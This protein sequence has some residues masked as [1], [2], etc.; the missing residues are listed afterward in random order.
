MHRRIGR[1][2]RGCG[3]FAAA[4][5]VATLFACEPKVYPEA[6]PERMV[7]LEAE[8]EPP[9]MVVLVTDAGD[10]AGSPDAGFAAQ[11]ASPPSTA[12]LAPAPDSTPSPAPISAADAGCMRVELFRDRDGDG[13][14]SAAPDDLIQDC[15]PV[16]GY[17]TNNLDCH[18]A[19]HTAQDP[20][21]DV[22][23]GQTEFFTAGYPTAN[24]ISFDYDCSELEE[25]D[26]SSAFV[27]AVANCEQREQ[28]CGFSIGYLTPA[29]E[30]SGA[31]V[32]A[33]CG[34]REEAWCTNAGD[35]CAL[36]AIGAAAP[37]PCH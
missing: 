15:P 14:G 29:E 7:A 19:E 22:F 10:T 1:A 28:P 17:V 18:D 37:V 12:L 30:R 13:F 32:D 34:A 24:G 25:V 31:G 5:A 3:R 36:L 33:L 4:L 8:A 2:G 21:G 9:A 16:A 11:E 26:P 27:P 6:A 23:P 35:G 20:A